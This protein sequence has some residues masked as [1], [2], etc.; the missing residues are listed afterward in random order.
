MADPE[1]TTPPASVPS[2]GNDNAAGAAWLMMSVVTAACMTIAV[3]W[4]SE[5]LSSSLIVFLR[6]VGGLVLALTAFSVVRRL[7]GQMRFSAPLL[8]VWRG[9]LIGIST[10]LGFYTISQIPLATATVL[11]FSAPIF[12]AL[13]AIPLHGEKV[14]LRRG[15]AIATG[16]AGVLLV[17]R[18]GIIP[19]DWAML[20]AIAS[21]FLFALALLSSRNLANRDGPFAAYLSSAVMTIIVSAPLALPAWSLPASS[22]GW[23]ALGLVVVMSLARNIGDLQAYRLA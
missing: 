15:G 13:I 19:F 8:H 14:G 12:A 21:S 4:S 6:S 11:F 3:R 9:G 18:P 10:Q 22:F 16:F 17:M 23:F 7:R 2:D 20:S 5:E 1:S